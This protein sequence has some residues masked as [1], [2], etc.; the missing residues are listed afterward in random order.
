MNNM[1]IYYQIVGN[2][3]IHDTVQANFSSCFNNQIYLQQLMRAQQSEQIQINVP[4]S[5]PRNPLIL[6]PEKSECQKLSVINPRLLP[7]PKCQWVGFLPCHGFV[8]SSTISPG[9][10]QLT[11]FSFPAEEGGPVKKKYKT[12]LNE[13][14][15]KTWVF[16]LF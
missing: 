9:P 14:L 15:V 10:C 12:R 13:Q 6:T 1:I 2:P 4:P 11:I 16:P 5:R 3:L 7:I 8:S